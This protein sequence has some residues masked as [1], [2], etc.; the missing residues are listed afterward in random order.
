MSKR[1]LLVADD[2]VCEEAICRAFEAQGNGVELV[3]ATSV[4]EALDRL[5]DQPLDLIIS[6]L[7]LP[8]GRCVD[9]ISAPEANS[10][11]PVIVLT[12]PND[13]SNA[14]E[15]RQAGAIDCL[16]KSA[17]LLADLPHIAERALIQ[18]RLSLECKPFDDQLFQADLPMTDITAR[19]KQ[20]R[21]A[22]ELEEMRQVDQSRKEFFSNVSHD[23][24]TPLGTIKGYTTML[25]DYY[26]RLSEAEIKNGLQS[27]DASIERMVN[28]IEQLLDMSQIDSHTLDLSKQPVSIPNLIADTVRDS[29]VSYPNHL[30]LQTFQ[31]DSPLPLVAI[32]PGRIRQVLDN[33]ISNAIKYSDSGTQVDISAYMDVDGEVVLYVADQGFGI[34]LEDLERIFDRMYRVRAHVASGVKGTGLG[35]SIARGIVEAHGGRMWVES[36]SGRGSTFYFSLPFE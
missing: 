32:D 15:I 20:D 22:M 1:F 21:Q 13:E 16:P 26:D 5:D 19:R 8:D 27:I 9:I 10:A 36:T 34:P 24:R 11:L 31:D 35:L 29:R 7:L 23:L 3:C 17:D 18:W 33:L 25:L 28:L 4:K 12:D 14:A 2:R 30:V 6:D